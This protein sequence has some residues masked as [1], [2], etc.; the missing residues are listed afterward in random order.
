MRN[1]EKLYKLMQQGLGDIEFDVD[2]Y[3]RKLHKQLLDANLY[4]GLDIDVIGQKQRECL[5]NAHLDVAFDEF[6]SRN[7]I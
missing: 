6:C 7:D 1:S 2:V 4:D 5:Q 3:T